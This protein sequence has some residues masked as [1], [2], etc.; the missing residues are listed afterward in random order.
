MSINVN[1]IEVFSKEDLYSRLNEILDV[2]TKNSIVGI[3][4]VRLTE[5][6]QLQLARDLGDIAGWFPNNTDKF[7]HKYIENHS[8][9]PSVGA[10]S[11]NELIL[12]WHLERVDYDEYLL[13]VAGVWNMRLFNCD[14]E[15]GKTYFIDSRKVFQKIYN[16]DE[17]NFLRGCKAYWTEQT[18]SGNTRTNYVKIV[19]PHWKTEEE[20]I[21]VELHHMAAIKLYKIN[22]NDPTSEE[23]AAFESL[24]KRFSQEIAN[25]E[26]LR[27]IH[28]WKEGD[29]L[30]PDLF[31][32][33]H[34]VTGGFDPKDREF[35]GYW[36]YTASPSSVGED[37][38][39]P[40]WRGE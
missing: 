23:A 17:K 38:V 22:D 18:P 35:T 16:E 25:N 40:S 11:N 37:N 14:P 9:N 19:Q 13:L 10:S 3:R 7:N 8:A 15:S 2:Q 21:R 31:S 29:I 12:S 32:L 28:K 20:Q 30:I 1:L 36:C 33:A 27:I 34:A 26:D 4:G 5:E 39:P 6:E 24:M